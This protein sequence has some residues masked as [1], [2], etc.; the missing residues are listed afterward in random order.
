MAHTAGG[1]GAEGR[2]GF[3]EAAC[4]MLMV[5]GTVFVEYQGMG[6]DE[7]YLAKA[8]AVGYGNALQLKLH[9]AF[10]YRYWE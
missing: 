2:D 1:I 3:G 5:N 10:G 8:Y 6:P 7:Q 9:L 4:F